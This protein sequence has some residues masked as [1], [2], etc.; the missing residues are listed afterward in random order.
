MVLF[1]KKKKL[2]LRD[3]EFST[4]YIIIHLCWRSLDNSDK[5]YPGFDVQEISPCLKGFLVI[6]MFITSCLF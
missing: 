2:I 1:M 3:T 6:I 4:I 5:V